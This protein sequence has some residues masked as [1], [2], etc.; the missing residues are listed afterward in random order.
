MR[1]D[2]VSN[3]INVKPFL[4]TL[5]GAAVWVVEDDDIISVKERDDPVL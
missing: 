3:L 4:F 5:M 2:L 1:Q